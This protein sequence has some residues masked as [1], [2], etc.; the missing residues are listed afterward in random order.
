MCA[1]ASVASVLSIDACLPVLEAGGCFVINALD[2]RGVAI[3]N[4]DCCWLA[5]RSWQAAVLPCGVGQVSMPNAPS[6]FVQCGQPMPITAAAPF[7]T[8]NIRAPTLPK[9]S[10]LA[11]CWKR[12][13]SSYPSS[14]PCHLTTSH[15]RNYAYGS[16]LFRD[17]V[18]ITLSADGNKIVA[19]GNNFPYY[20]SSDKGALAVPAASGTTVMQTPRATSMQ[21]FRAFPAGKTWSNPWGNA[22][23][24][25]VACSSDGRVQWAAVNG[26]E[27]LLTANNWS[28]VY[29]SGMGNKPWTR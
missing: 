20:Y 7:T 10:A 2:P 12:D 5:I 11:K 9:V 16:C 14:Y 17:W 23:W 3:F 13:S 1:P 22:A 19:I 28:S 29:Y 4:L 8:C 26:E 15:T 18:G 21:S 24:S 27:V 25:A 6:R